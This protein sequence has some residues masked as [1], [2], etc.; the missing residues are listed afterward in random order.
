[1]P[2]LLTS[3]NVGSAI[4]NQG[5]ANKEDLVT[6]GSTD[7]IAGPSYLQLD[8]LRECFTQGQVD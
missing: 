6:K 1:M 7:L 3:S 2:N 5:A 8:C 4:D